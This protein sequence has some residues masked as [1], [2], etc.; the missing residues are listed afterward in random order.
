MQMAFFF[1]FSKVPLVQ[2]EKIEIHNTIW[3]WI[4]LDVLKSEISNLVILQIQAMHFLG[5]LIWGINVPSTSS[6]RLN[7]DLFIQNN[8][9]IEPGYISLYSD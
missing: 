6:A 9:A 1:K 5:N 4:W 3:S 7:Q 2:Y 8:Y